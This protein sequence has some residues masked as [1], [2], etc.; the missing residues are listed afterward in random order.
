MRAA[1]IISLCC[2]A[3]FAALAVYAGVQF[4]RTADLGEKVLYSSLFVL[5][6]VFVVTTKLWYWMLA[7]RNGIQREIKRL[8][9]RVAEMS[10]KL[11]AK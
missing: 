2:M 5:A 10:E 7:N 3:A 4:F 6:M 1:S 8:E 9:L 11:A